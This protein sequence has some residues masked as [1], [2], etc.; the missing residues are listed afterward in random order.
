MKKGGRKLVRSP[1]FFKRY[2]AAASVMPAFFF[3]QACASAFV[4]KVVLDA[5]FHCPSLPTDAVPESL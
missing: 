4:S 5:L 1:V 3:S 2:Y